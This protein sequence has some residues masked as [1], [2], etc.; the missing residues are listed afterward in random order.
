MRVR[1]VEHQCPVLRASGVDQTNNG[2]RM[3]ADA[4]DQ[5]SILTGIFLILL[6]A[7]SLFSAE[8]L[9]ARRV[10]LFPE[11]NEKTMVLAY[12]ACGGVLLIVGAFGLASRFA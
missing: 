1:L 10:R 12:R 5:L 8:R 4:S 2:R 9:A 11:T 3:I 7:W 6:G